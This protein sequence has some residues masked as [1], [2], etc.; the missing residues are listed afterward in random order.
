MVGRAP[1]VHDEGAG[2]GYAASEANQGLQHVTDIGAAVLATT[3]G[4]EAGHV[5]VSLATE[6]GGYHE[7]TACR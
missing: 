1:C 4:L 7:L 3:S 5:V 2:G 6:K